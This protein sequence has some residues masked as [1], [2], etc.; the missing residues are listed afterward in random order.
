MISNTIDSQFFMELYHIFDVFDL[1]RFLF[2][3]NVSFDD[4]YGSDHSV[5]PVTDFGFLGIPLQNGVLGFISIGM[6]FSYWIKYSSSELKTF[7]LIN[8]IIGLLHYF[9]MISFPGI[10]VISW[11]VRN[12]ERIKPVVV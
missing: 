8:L 11:L 2:G 6:I 12:S 4:Q 3:F 5:I 10:V 7:I 1:E 9:P